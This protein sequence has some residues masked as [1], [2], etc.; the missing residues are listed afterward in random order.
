[1]NGLQIFKNER[2]GEVRVAGTSET[3]FFCLVDICRV[4]E[5][6]NVSDCKSR[7][8]QEGVVLTEEVLKTTNQYGV[9]TEQVVML[10]FISEQN[11]YKV[12]MQSDKPQAK[13]FWDWVCG[14]VLPTIR[15]GSSVFCE[16]APL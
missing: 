8:E 14:D 11:L 5:I 4:L 2:F 12:I 15:E 7:L 6:K 1:M 10:T 9:N 16:Q 3:P 13:P